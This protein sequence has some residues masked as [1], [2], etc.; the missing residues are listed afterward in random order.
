M[1][2]RLLIISTISCIFTLTACKQ[3]ENPEQNKD[4]KVE[5]S[6][7]S[8]KE[9]ESNSAEITQ[10]QANDDSKTKE[11]PAQE[12]TRLENLQ[13]KFTEIMNSNVGIST[14]S[15][16][17]Q[18]KENDI[19]IGSNDAK[20]TIVEYSSLTCP[21][22]K[23]YHEKTYSK[24]KQ[25]FIDTNKVRYIVR[26]VASDQQSYNGAVMARCAKEPSKVAQ[27]LSVLYSNQDTWAFNKKS[28]AILENI[29]QLGGVS[30]DEFEKCLDNEEITNKILYDTRDAFNILSISGTPTIFVQGEKISGSNAYENVSKEI[31]KHLNQ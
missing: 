28:K 16:V 11:E 20:I 13:A 23:Y 25:D 27:F 5:E 14:P 21:G 12:K 29:G 6:S 3:S 2:T 1:I 31:E 17:L 19:V 7:T 30:S 24:I 18:I 8:S 9:N 26:P 10:E 22:C 15:T 4:T